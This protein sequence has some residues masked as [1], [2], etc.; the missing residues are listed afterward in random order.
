MINVDK[1]VAYWRDSALEDW[2][3]AGSLIQGGRQRHGLFFAH[4]ALEKMLKAHVCR[5]VKDVAPRIHNLVQLADRAK[6][7]ISSDQRAFLARFDQYQQAGR[8][9]DMLIKGP[10][11]AKAKSELQEAQEMMKW[12]IAQF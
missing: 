7:T 12:L 1:Q 11:L 10:T 9:P 4:L 3:V 6:L 2:D 5:Q 8:Y